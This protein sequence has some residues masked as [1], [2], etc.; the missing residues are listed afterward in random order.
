MENSFL[1]GFKRILESKKSPV[2]R[3]GPYRRN[4]CRRAPISLGYL[5]EVIST[6][7]PREQQG[8]SFSIA[9]SA[10][11]ISTKCGYSKQ[12]CHSNR[13][14]SSIPIHVNAWGLGER[15]GDGER[16]SERR[17]EEGRQAGRQA[18]YQKEWQWQYFTIKPISVSQRRRRRRR[19]R[20]RPRRRS[21]GRSVVDMAFEL[22]ARSRRR[23]RR[24]GG[25][26]RRR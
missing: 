25:A 12:S 1:S 6:G 23:L 17:H 15:G 26:K 5:D 7:S 13:I 8:I 2:Y 14:S 10:N 4:I 20:R 22:P 9:T 3:C 18:G 11:E 21:V 19:R 24:G 16:A